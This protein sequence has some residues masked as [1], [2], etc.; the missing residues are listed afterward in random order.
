MVNLINVSSTS[1]WV[2]TTIAISHRHS[3][4]LTII[5]HTR[6][7]VVQCHEERL[8]RQDQGGLL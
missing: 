4:T 5:Q 1:S 8:H 6:T 7:S 3:M 2:N